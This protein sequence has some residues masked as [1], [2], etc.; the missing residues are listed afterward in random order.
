MQC[1]VQ[2]FMRRFSFLGGHLNYCM[3]AIGIPAEIF[4]II[5][6]IGL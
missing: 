5:V 3:E 4:T 1:K 6:L 2:L